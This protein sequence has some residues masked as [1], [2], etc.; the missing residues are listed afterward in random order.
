MLRKPVRRTNRWFGPRTAAR[1]IAEAAAV[2]SAAGLIA[3]SLVAIA[4]E[5]PHVHDHGGYALGGVEVSV[6]SVA[7][8]SHDMFGG[9]MPK[10][11][12]N[13]PM[14]PQM[15]PGMPTGDVNRLHV[16]VTVVNHDGSPF[17]YLAAE[18]RIESAQDKSWGPTGDVQPEQAVIPGHTAMA[19]EL[20]FD[21]PVAQTAKTLRFTRGSKRLTIPLVA[22]QAPAH[23]HD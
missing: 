8:L 6:D 22:G 18:F 2:L 1:L 5:R 4:A 3:V 7:W 13:F 14:P 12:K 11:A 16:E 20:F 19:V 23:H 17:R 9:P 21:I 10:T 15:M